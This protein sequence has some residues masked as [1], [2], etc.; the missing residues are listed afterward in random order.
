MQWHGEEKWDEFFRTAVL[1]ERGKSM[2]PSRFYDFL[3]ELQ[4]PHLRLLAESAFH[5]LA[6]VKFANQNLVRTSEIHRTVAEEFFP[7][8]DMTQCLRTVFEGSHGEDST[9]WVHHKR[10]LWLYY[11][12]D[13]FGPGS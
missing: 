8:I 9:M 13:R 10:N 11:A 2:I 4:F 7:R 5:V 3:E 1:F 6:G 12:E